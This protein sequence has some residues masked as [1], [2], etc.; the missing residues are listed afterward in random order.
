VWFVIH[1]TVHV[2]VV[3]WLYETVMKSRV[4]WTTLKADSDFNAQN[5]ATKTLELKA[6]GVSCNDFLVDIRVLATAWLHKQ[7]VRERAKFMKTNFEWQ[8]SSCQWRVYSRYCQTV[9]STHTEEQWN[10]KNLQLAH[11]VFSLFTD[12]LA[13]LEPSHI[14][15]CCYLHLYA[16]Y[17][18]WL[19]SSSK[20]N[21]SLLM[22][23]Q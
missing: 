22:R 10:Y 21:W 9:M 11:A 17:R 20:M 2:D 16:A 14:F 5:C 1:R 6:S 7:K 13:L 19:Q 15:W 3:I 18:M 4:K 12:M 8:I 23:H